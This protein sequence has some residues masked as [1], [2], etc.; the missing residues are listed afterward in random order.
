MDKISL[1]LILSS[2]VTNALGSTIMKHAYGGDSRTGQL[3][4]DCRK[5]HGFDGR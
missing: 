5:G 2:A 1:F 3:V 4:A